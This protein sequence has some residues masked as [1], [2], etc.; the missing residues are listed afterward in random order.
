M[1]S[2]ALMMG[3]ARVPDV[4]GTPY[5]GGYYVGRI[6]LFSGWVYA[7][8]VA[9]KALGESPSP[10][11]WGTSETSVLNTIS[12]IDGPT[13]T[14]F[15]IQR[16]A[17]LHPAANFCSNLT[18]GGFNDWYLPARDELEILYRNLKPTTRTNV[19]GAGVNPYSV[20]P[21]DNYTTSD[22]AQTQ[23]EDFREGGPEAFAA[24]IYWSSTQR[25]DQTHTAWSITFAHGN[26]L[27]TIKTYTRRVRAVRRVPLYLE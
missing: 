17:S 1:L 6:R 27:S 20:P 19:T 13:N 22:P 10:L 12:N 26:R 11:L 16:G 23:A 14:Q 15:M 24:D 2:A 21:T 9:P 3:G 7:L 25:H 5:E 18:I 4:P 8:I